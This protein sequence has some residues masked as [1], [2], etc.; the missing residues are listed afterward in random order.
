MHPPCVT[1]KP[2]SYSGYIHIVGM[3]WDP[4]M[5]F[6]PCIVPVFPLRSTWRRVWMDVNALVMFG[7]MQPAYNT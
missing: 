6:N 1:P 3:D 2:D 7:E 4:G 5:S